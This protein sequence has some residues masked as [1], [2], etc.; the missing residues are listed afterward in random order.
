MIDTR[1]AAHTAIYR[2]LAADTAVA[3]LADVWGHAEEGTEP[4]DAK[5][6]ILVGL[7]STDSIAGKDGGL[8]EVTIEVYAYVRKPDV[9]ALYEVS[10]AVRNAIEGKPMTAPGALVSGPEFLSAESDLMEDGETYTDTLRFRTIV[11]DA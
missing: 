4:T 3:A 9:T 1:T 10:A 11:Q 7:A 5:G 8:D 6:I 2:A